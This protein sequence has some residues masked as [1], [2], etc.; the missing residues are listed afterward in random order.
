MPGA[1]EG[2]P[3][4]RVITGARAADGARQP[5]NDDAPSRRSGHHF[6]P[7]RRCGSDTEC[8]P[9]ELCFDGDCI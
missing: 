1:R 4:L 3:A 8:A 9:D 7:F 5:A 2:R 6:P